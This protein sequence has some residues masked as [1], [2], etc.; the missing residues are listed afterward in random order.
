MPRSSSSAIQTFTISAVL[1]CLA[2]GHVFR[3]GLAAMA[4]RK[5]DSCKKPFWRAGLV[6]ER[7][8]TVRD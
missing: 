4:A 7:L 5:C 2:C 6:L 8:L 1:R 3:R